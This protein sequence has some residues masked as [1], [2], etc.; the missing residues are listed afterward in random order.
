M[1][2]TPITFAAAAQPLAERGWRPFPGR[3]SSKI[4]AMCGWPGL[5]VAEWDRA[6]LEAT[7]AEYQPTDDF[8]CCLAVQ[9]EVTA[10]DLDILDAGHAA[11]ADSLANDILGK[12]PLVRIGYAPKQVRIYRSGD[13][14]RSRK[15]HPLEIFSGSGQF[16]G[17]GW[18]QKAGRPYI[19][20]E[21]SPLDVC[22][23]SDVIPLV[24]R[25]Q[26]DRFAFELFKVVPRRLLPTGQARTGSISTVGERLRMLTT[27][28]GSWKRAAAIVLSEAVDGLRNETAWAV[29]SSAA[30]RGISEDLVW[31]VF[32]RHFRG[33]DGVSKEQL[34]DMIERASAARPSSPMI[35]TTSAGGRHVSGR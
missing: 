33:W 4:P 10:V 19:W 28:H 6:D 25:A 12:T 11:T 22:A 18:H 3:Q 26:L 9:P 21:L 13:V 29:V 2:D 20:P 15:L 34:S 5:N 14:I 31:E 16:I 23:D 8:C 1:M 30:G 32:E 7:R 17:F 35:F 27:L 24:T